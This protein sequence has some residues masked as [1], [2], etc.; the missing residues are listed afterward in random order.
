M[1]A[2]H[3]EHRDSAPASL[4]DDKIFD[5]FDE[6]TAASKGKQASYP[7][8]E[9]D[10]AWLDSVD[11]KVQRRIYNKVDVRLVP[12]LA[13]LYL[14]AHLDRANI[15]N[16]KI[17]GLE[18]SLNMTGNDYNVALMVFFIPYVCQHSG[19]AVARAFADPKGRS[20]VRSRRTSF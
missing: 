20:C 11:A 4:K 14:I 15:G 19:Y 2:T 10:R 1:T 8:S 16:A 7:L 6:K 12:M 9:D 17:E 18:D 5:T 3:H 13:L